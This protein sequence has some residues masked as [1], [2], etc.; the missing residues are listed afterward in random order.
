MGG[1]VRRRPVPDG[2][3]R[4][5]ETDENRVD[6]A[7]FD[8]P[9]RGAW[10]GHDGYGNAFMYAID[11]HLIVT[12]TLNNAQADWGAMVEAVQASLPG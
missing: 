3:A 4:A 8:E 12:G 11:P 6:G 7:A 10:E 1:V 2:Y 5:E 9:E